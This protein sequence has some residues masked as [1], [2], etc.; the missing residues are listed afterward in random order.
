M[1]IAIRQICNRQREKIFT[2]NGSSE[3]QASLR[4]KWMLIR[5][6]SL[7]AGHE[8]ELVKAYVNQ[9]GCTFRV[10]AASCGTFLSKCLRIMHGFAVFPLL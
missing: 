3:W 6:R 5:E 8:L 2:R 1:S 10:I 4:K 7:I 9:P